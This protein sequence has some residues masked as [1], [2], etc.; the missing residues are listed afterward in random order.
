VGDGWAAPLRRLLRRAFLKHTAYKWEALFGVAGVP[1]AAHRT[2]VEW[3]D[4]PHVRAAG[5]VREEDGRLR[6]G[7]VAWVVESQAAE[8]EVCLCI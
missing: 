3:L 6:P 2:T 7:A 5:L 1:G 4:S 8:E